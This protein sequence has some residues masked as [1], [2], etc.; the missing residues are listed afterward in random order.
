MGRVGG[1]LKATD[2]VLGDYVGNAQKCAGAVIVIP[3]EIDFGDLG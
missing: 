1:T 3:K 2:G